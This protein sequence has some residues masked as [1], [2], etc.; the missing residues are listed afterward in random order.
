MHRRY[1]SS[2]LLSLFVVAVCIFSGIRVFQP[3]TL[4]FATQIIDAHTAEI[5]P[6]PGMPLP[7]G[8]RTGDKIDFA[9]LPRDTRIIFGPTLPL[10]RSYDIVVDRD[11]TLLTVPVVI[12]S[13]DAT[14]IPGLT[15]YHWIA[16][17]FYIL[18]GT[19]VLLALWRGR[20]RAA[21]GL[22]FWGVAF[23]TGLA[24]SY[25]PADGFVVATALL[26][27]NVIYL[28]AR[29]AFYVMVE[30]MVESA[31]TPR[32]RTVWRASFLLLLA[33]GAIQTLGGPVIFVATGWAEL[34]KPQYGLAL[35]ASY[36]VPI[37]MLFVSYRHADL[38]QR[39]RLRWML[40]GSVF[41]V[42]GIFLNNTRVLGFVGSAIVW[43]VMFTLALA[44]ILYAVLRHRVVDVA[45]VLDRTL[46]Y[47][48]MTALVVGVLAA[49]NSLVQHAALGSNASL[50]LQVIVPLALGIVLNRARGY[51]DRIV[52]Q[53][54]FR[55]RYLA[56]KAL[57]AFARR[58]SHIADPEHL[59]DATIEALR[60]HMGTPAV[61][62]YERSDSGYACLRQAGIPAY[63]NTVGVDDP[64]MVA[65]RADLK[66]VDL[67]EFASTLGTE[68]YLFP[69]V[70]SG[71]LQGALVCANRPGEHFAL[72]ER[73][74]M[75]KVARQVGLARQA[76]LARES[77]VFVGAV[78]RGTLKPDEAR[79]QALKLEATWMTS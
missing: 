44:C 4:P 23:L 10:G 16:V 50:L 51:V 64:S 48:A 12:T 43:S 26:A 68:G 40:W 70:V 5:S 3:T 66:A 9:A 65:A 74:L 21:T 31:L 77:Q 1:G 72:D 55:Q 33:V 28:L 36:L 76:I 54:F 63:P 8:L 34:L 38:V 71:K 79:Q 62:I 53:V 56:D 30:S 49:V 46:V 29:T 18:M 60:T 59:L 42:V 69:M 24:M 20:D 37:A 14:A 45:V 35:T 39:L 73:K 11:G 52:E 27:T 41:F 78:A 32:K 22:V 67:S 17:C 7:P 47:G 13:V 25:I 19:I 61:A 6:I 57:R 15:A 58:C 2:I 75:A